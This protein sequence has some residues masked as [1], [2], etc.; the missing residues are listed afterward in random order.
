MNDL[1]TDEIRNH[2]VDKANKVIQ[3]N[4]NTF[5]ANWVL[6]NP[7]EDMNNWIMCYQNDWTEGTT[8]FWMEKKPDAELE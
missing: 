8:R 2:I 5:I 4:E 3:D 1:S 7:D 6:Q